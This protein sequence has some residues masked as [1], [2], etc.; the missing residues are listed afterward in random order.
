M[1]E[2]LQ[3]KEIIVIG[4]EVEGTCLFCLEFEKKV[5]SKYSGTIPMRSAP[6]SALKGFDL[7]TQT[8][9]TPTIIFIEDGKEIWSHQGMMSS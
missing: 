6:A 4:P 2:P 1:I 5:T 7:K 9:A 8:W 3:G